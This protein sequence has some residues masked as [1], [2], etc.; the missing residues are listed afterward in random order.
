MRGGSESAPM[1]SR[2]C[3]MSALCVMNA[4]MRICPPHSG[5][6]R[7][8]LNIHS[9]LTH[10]HKGGVVTAERPGCWCLRAHRTNMLRRFNY[11]APSQVGIQP[12]GQ[13]D[14]RRRDTRLK[15]RSYDLAFEVVTVASAPKSRLR[16]LN[17]WS[18]HVSA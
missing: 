3:R 8:K 13:C 9:A 2:M 6:K 16:H 14:C 4:M 11:P 18:V 17:F 5:H 10:G 1:W 7:G 12:V 15:A